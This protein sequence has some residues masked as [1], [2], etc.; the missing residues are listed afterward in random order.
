ME[1]PQATLLLCVKDCHKDYHAGK[2]KLNLKRGQSLK[3]AAFMGIM[4]WY[5]FIIGSKEYILM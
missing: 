1:I 4:R 3:D 5:I 2:L